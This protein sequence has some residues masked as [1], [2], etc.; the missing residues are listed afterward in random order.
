[1]NNIRA[2]LGIMLSINHVPPVNKNTALL[3]QKSDY[4]LRLNLHKDI[5]KFQY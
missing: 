3:V 1:M 4:P 5:D 2:A